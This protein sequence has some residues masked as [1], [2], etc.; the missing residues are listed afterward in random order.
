MFAS[1]VCS[2]DPL[3]FF[4][5]ESSPQFAEVFGADEA[6]AELSGSDDASMTLEFSGAEAPVE[7][8]GTDDASLLAATSDAGD[9]E[10]GWFSG[11]LIA[12]A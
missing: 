2:D 7:L 1:D 5:A 10:P 12:D 11:I 4:S 3:G 8:S 6:P 9:F